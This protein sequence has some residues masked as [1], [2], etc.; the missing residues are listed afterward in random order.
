MRYNAVTHSLDVTEVQDFRQ[1]KFSPG[2]TLSKPSLRNIRVNSFVDTLS[3]ITVLLPD[4][5]RFSVA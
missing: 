3:S 1:A 5:L 2:I 4:I